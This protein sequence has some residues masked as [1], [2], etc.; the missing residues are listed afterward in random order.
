MPDLQGF[1][2]PVAAVNDSNSQVAVIE[3][4]AGL[5]WVV[6]DGHREELNALAV[7]YRST[8]S[9]SSG[10]WLVAGCSSHL[11]GDVRTV[12]IAV[13]SEGL[14]LEVEADRPAWIVAIPAEFGE[15]P[16]T[17]SFHR[18]D[19]TQWERTFVSPDGFAS[20]VSG[21]AGGIGAEGWTS[22]API[23]AELG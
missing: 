6:E 10:C 5:L 3:D 18:G 22:Y 7:V 9:G 20:W 1:G 2:R 19:G 23:S 16:S 4:Q 21:D 14:V 15:L 11:P 17:L 12:R 13:P 8:G